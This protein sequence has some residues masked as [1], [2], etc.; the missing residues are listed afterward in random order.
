MSDV[1]SKLRIL[2]AGDRAWASACE[3]AWEKLDFAVDLAQP[4]QDL[5]TRL[6]DL[7]RS[8]SAVVVD[9][10]AID[11]PTRV[12]VF[13][14]LSQT[15][16]T[17]LILLGPEK[18]AARW[19]PRINLPLGNLFD[20]VVNHL[21]SR[22]LVLL[23]TP[24]IYISGVVSERLTRL[25]VQALPLETPIGLKEVLRMMRPAPSQTSTVNLL[26]RVSGGAPAAAEETPKAAVVQW[27][28]SDLEAESLQQGLQI[29]YPDAVCLLLSDFG[30][31]R[32][33]ASCL[34]QAKPGVLRKDMLAW[35]PKLVR[36]ERIEEPGFKGRVLVTENFKPELLSITRTLLEDG[37][38]VA[39]SIDNQKAI[40]M[41]QR[42]PF[43]VAIVGAALAYATMTGI[44]VA[45][46]IRQN[47]PDTRIILLAEKYPLEAALKG[48]SEV[49]E[50]G[51]DDCLLKPAEPKIL[52]YAVARA[53]EKRRLILE[54]ARLF[55]ELK[56]TNSQLGQLNSFQ[57]KFFA[58]VAHD[59]K[60]PLA[61]IQGY[62]QM[63]ERRLKDPKDVQYNGSI[64]A[65]AKTLTALISDL[66][67]L[68]AIES[69]KLRINKTEI[70]LADVVAE[71][72]SRIEI[73]AQQRSIKFT[74]NPLPPAPRIQGDP[75]RLGQVLQNLC[76][77]AI[78]YTP[79]GGSVTVTVTVTESAKEIRVEVQDTG[80]GISKEDLPRV[81][82]RFFQT[83]QA[84]K[85][86]KAGFGLGLKIAREVVQAHGGEIA[87]ESEL[88]KG[89]LFY[90][91]LPYGQAS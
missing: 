53:M 63:L 12:R 83:E 36:R 34:R 11:V 37:W 55:A 17:S 54:N 72:S 21:K 69:G 46:K 66:V 50:V 38:E 74:M 59:V 68:A 7:G 3:V 88:G 42:Q 62:S 49:A 26:Q 57:T 9:D 52:L 65:A 16:A 5:E 19:P 86:R 58:T 31:V 25:G 41:V 81:W 56:D 91:T 27:E 39:A 79:E 90:F 20:A 47:D 71:V 6:A 76:T 2:L 14:R 51:L 10:T 77:N 13:Q 29:E 64:M 43:D 70:S 30:P 82:Q 61:A 23:V 73:A 32:A 8:F 60:N 80:I 18:G 24:S 87:V 67:D 40:E 89:S 35:V 45:Q 75:Q 1:E 78:N 33:A 22:R 48:I 15:P 85:M 28:G 4:G 44:Q 84:Q